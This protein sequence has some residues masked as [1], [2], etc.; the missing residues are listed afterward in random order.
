MAQKKLSPDAEAFISIFFFVNSFIFWVLSS[1]WPDYG[2]AAASHPVMSLALIP[3]F[4]FGVIPGN[5]LAWGILIGLILGM[6]APGQ[7]W[8]A[9]TSIACLLLAEYFAYG[10]IRYKKP[11]DGNIPPA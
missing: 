9:A 2:S 3:A 4:L 1:V 5:K 7:E 11:A 6:C 10:W 8:L